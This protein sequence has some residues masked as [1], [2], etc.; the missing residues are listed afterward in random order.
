MSPSDA[1][2]QF[3]LSEDSFAF[4]ISR[5]DTGEVLFDTTGSP[6]VFES[7]YVYLKTQLPQDPNIYGLGEHSD[8]LRFPTKDYHRVFWNAESPFIPREENLYSS[9]PVYF[10]H[11]GANGT[12]G[13]FL[14]NSNGMQINI[15]QTDDGDQFLEYNTLGGVLDFYFLA[16]PSP[17]EVS[18]QYAEVVGLPAMMPYWTFGFHQCKFGYRDVFELAEVVANYSKAN[19][20]LEVM[21]SDID[22]MDYRKVFTTDPERYQL[23]L[24]R[25]LV[26][27]I[28]EREQYFVMMLD[29]GIGQSDDYETYRRGREKDVFLKAEDG[30]DYRGVQWAG[31]VVWPDWL[32][33]NTHEWWSNEISMF[34]DPETGIDI[35]GAWNDMNEAS[36]FVPNI[37]LDPE[38]VARLSNN[39]PE[40]KYPPRADTGREIPGF[41]EEFQPRSRSRVRARESSAESDRANVKRLATRS[42]AGIQLE[43]VATV[44]TRQESSGDM[45]G[46]PGRDLLNPGY[47]ISNHRGELSDSTIFTNTSNLDGTTQYDTH[48]LYGATMATATYNSM[49]ERRPGKRPFVLTRSSFAGSGNKVAH[50]FGDNK[51]QW[52]DY[53][54][55]IPQLL[56]FTAVH[57]MPM[58]GSDICGFNANTTETMC[59][60]W[61]MLGAFMPFYRNHAVDEASPQEFYQWESVAEA[62]RKAIDARYRLLDYIYTAMHRASTTGEPIAYPL[63]YLYPSDENTFGI[64]MQY[65]YGDA[66]MISPVI[67]D[68]ADVVEFYMPDNIF[69]DFWTHEPIRGKGA[70]ITAKDQAL[71]DI[72]IHIRGGK[73]LPLRTESA[74]TTTQ[75]RKKNFSLVVAPGLD[76]KAE[77]S[78]YLDDGESVDVGD[79]KSDIRFTWDGQTL[80]SEGTYGFS[81]DLTIDHVTVLDGESAGEALTLEV[82]WRLDGP[83]ENELPKK[84]SNRSD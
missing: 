67:E 70:N 37:T 12:H 25:K 64:D 47:K 20:P 33:P 15:D 13:V 35:D 56:T 79:E 41:P 52:D 11:R 49:L 8:S 40:P 32:A 4:S 73:I 36:N 51:S 14:L 76:G 43:S 61:A 29:P 57:Q 44:Y 60:R 2:L 21:W 45:K 65:F 69:Y 23:D 6:L 17:T 58:V 10:D 28:H 3:S 42:A 72:P 7:Q 26:D 46:L 50:W 74:N 1:A 77:G 22:Y 38:L 19:I 81:T 68:D 66:L 84:R 71:T 59:A 80:K 53:R 16:G 30:S 5:S 9:H 83:F 18:K 31:V 54:V 27:T 48:N 75:L 78:L 24:M 82:S 39:P 34:F 63:F 55:Q 62:A